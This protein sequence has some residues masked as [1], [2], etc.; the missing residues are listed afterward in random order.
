LVVKLKIIIDSSLMIAL[1]QKKG[2]KMEDLNSLSTELFF[3]KECFE[4]IRKKAKFK[5]IYRPIIHGISKMLEKSR[6]KLLKLNDGGKSADDAIVDYL[7]KSNDK[8]VVATGDMH[9]AR[10]LKSMGFPVILLR[11][12]GRLE[13]PNSI[14]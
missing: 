6:V 5:P 13:I 8:I 7:K 10:R 4:E 3:P 11:K 14:M 12:D 9:L 2:L 1:F